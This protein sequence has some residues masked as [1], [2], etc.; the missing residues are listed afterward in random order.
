MTTQ[1]GSAY[2]V[3]V[4]GASL[5]TTYGLVLTSDTDLGAP[6]AKTYTV[7]IPGGNGSID[8]TEALTGDVAY[9]TYEMKLVLSTME[10]T[11]V[12]ALRQRLRSRYHGRRLDYQLAIDPGYTYTGRFEVGV[13]SVGVELPGGTRHA[14]V[15]L[16]VTADPYKL[17]EHCSYRL[18]ATG[19]RWYRFESGRRPVHPTIECESVCF[20]AWDGETITVPAGAY[21]L[22]DVVFREGWND[23]YVNSGRI[24]VETWAD[25]G[26]GGKDAMTWAQA[27]AYNWDD[28]QRLGVGDSEG[29]PQA[30]ADLGD[31]TW[32]DE[33]A[34]T[35]ADVDYRRTED[36]LLGDS[37]VYLTYDW[38]DL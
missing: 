28:V 7:D 16:A 27:S 23:L 26:K 38:E 21:R 19:G 29:V 10:P 30:W 24:W 32:A 18:N 35:W 6:E 25:A 8:L 15:T 3:T 4:D 33:S 9:D 37:T 31:A 14:T 17:K 13:E 12:R 22:N 5:L 1:I 20:V 2:D 34:K 11:D 36:Y